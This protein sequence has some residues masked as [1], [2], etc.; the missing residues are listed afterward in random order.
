MKEQAY[1]YLDKC[2][3]PEQCDV[4]SAIEDLER[5]AARYTKD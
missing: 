1:R 5:H 2:Q 3:D 4:D